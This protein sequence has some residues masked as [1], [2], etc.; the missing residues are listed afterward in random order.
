M[1]KWLKK[2]LKRYGRW[3]VVCIGVLLFANA[4]FGITQSLEEGRELYLVIHIFG[5]CLWPFIILMIFGILDKI[6]KWWVRD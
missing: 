3:V 4:I 1:K 6:Y 2:W 5:A